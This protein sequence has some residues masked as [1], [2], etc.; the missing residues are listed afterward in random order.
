M[1]I[2]CFVLFGFGFVDNETICFTSCKVWVLL[3]T[4]QL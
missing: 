1:Y 4:T 2:I 3:L